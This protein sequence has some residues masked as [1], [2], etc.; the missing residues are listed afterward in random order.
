MDQSN[1]TNFLCT[2][3]KPATQTTSAPLHNPMRGSGRLLNPTRNGLLSARPGRKRAQ[4]TRGAVRLN[5]PDSRDNQSNRRNLFIVAV[6]CIAASGL[7]YGAKLADSVGM[8]PM[9]NT[10]SLPSSPLQQTL[11]SKSLL[12]R[13]VP[14]PSFRFDDADPALWD[15][16]VAR[17]EHEKQP[18]LNGYVRPEL[19]P[20]FSPQAIASMP[21][22]EPSGLLEVDASIKE[23][24][25]NAEKNLPPLQTDIPHQNLE[26]VEA[27]PLQSD[28]NK[29]V[30]VQPGDSFSKILNDNGIS[31]ADLPALED[32][33]LVQRHLTKLKVGQKMEFAFD[34][35]G[36]F[37]S[38]NV[39]VSRDTRV[40]LSKEQSGYT[41]EKI[42][43]A[44][45]YERVVTSGTIDQSLYLAAEKANLNQTTI[46]TLAEIF[47]WELDFS[48]D[49]RK[50]DHFSIIYDRL[51][52][53]G[54]YVG[55]GDILAAEFVRGDRV[56]R[57][58]RFTND[59]DVTAY[60]SPDGKAK[61]RSFNRHPVEIVR[62]TSKFDPNRMHP[63]LHTIR[64]HKGVDYGSPYGS[65]I[66]AVADGRISFSGNRNAYGKT[67]II[68]HDSKR[69]T[70]YAHMS[71]IDKL[72]EVGKKI[73][74]G[75]VIGYVGKTGRV[76]G[77]HLHYELRINGKH[78]DPLKVELPSP[79]PLAAKDLPRLK[80]I[81]NELIAQM[82]S[83]NEMVSDASSS[84]K[85][86]LLDF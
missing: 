46:M 86:A 68:K 3:Y 54:K 12:P 28:F 8:L 43:L 84:S 55:D 67:V 66:K 82:R 80:A 25:A 26:I 19:V 75:D 45:E 40:L 31:R 59:E 79:P 18:E 22:E 23:A 60:Y 74:R 21:A 78:V 49:I 52:R 30:E 72:S 7:I 62:I 33:A 16:A 53:D 41:L 50:G 4:S 6:G 35:Q 48:N 58:I 34:W 37:K 42:H 27:A 73:K 44:L 77:T 17:I 9:A 11:L 76:T 29:I 36:E 38:L 85:E 61:G 81:S 1:S 63:V 2:D 69:T 70:L 5:K 32:H 71:R 14:Q 51:Y 57:A 83:V 24:I 64:A 10:A 13:P 20:S 56:H 39:K 65:P 47:Q 15:A